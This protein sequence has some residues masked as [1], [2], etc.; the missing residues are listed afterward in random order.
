[1]KN[2]P[3]CNIAWE[4][5]K[6]I[7]D[8]FLST[9]KNEEEAREAAASYGDTKETPKHF[10][11]NCVGIETEEYDGVSYWKCTSCNAVFDRW[12]MKETDKKFDFQENDS[13]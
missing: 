5:E 9:G 10:G 1:M 11:K 8:H 2:C 12:T 4:E 7:Y 6:T 3:K 13:V